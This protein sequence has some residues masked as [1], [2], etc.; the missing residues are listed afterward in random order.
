MNDD[1]AL[2]IVVLPVPVPPLMRTLPLVAPGARTKRVPAVMAL[3]A[4]W[5]KVPLPW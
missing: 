3:P 5:V 1:S 4:L 2:S